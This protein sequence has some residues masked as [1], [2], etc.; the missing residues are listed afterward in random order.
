MVTSRPPT[1]LTRDDDG[2]ASPTVAIDRGFLLAGGDGVCVRLPGMGVPWDGWGLRSYEQIGSRGR[3]AMF[4]N[5]ARRANRIQPWGKC[6][7]V[8]AAGDYAQIVGSG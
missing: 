1:L 8:G 5:P 3:T 7:H 2:L 6:W 4:G